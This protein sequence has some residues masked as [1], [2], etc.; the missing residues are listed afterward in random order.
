MRIRRLLRAFSTAAYPVCILWFE[1]LFEEF[2]DGCHGVHLEQW[3]RTI[4][5][6]LN[7]YASQAKFRFN[8]TYCSG[9]DMAIYNY[10]FYHTLLKLFKGTLRVLPLI[11]QYKCS[12]CPTYS[13]SWINKAKTWLSCD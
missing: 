13:K 4:L 8:P 7:L 9:G 3:N 5:T 12:Y 11:T 6:S 2:K 1:I 10:M